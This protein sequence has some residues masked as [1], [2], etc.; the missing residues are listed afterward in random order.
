MIRRGLGRFFDFLRANVVR[1]FVVAAALVVG[2]Y[3]YAVLFGERS[4]LV[5]LE[6]HEQQRDLHAQIEQLQQKNADLQREFFGAGGVQFRATKG[7]K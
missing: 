5:L 4:L 2:Y 3:L 7:I 6:L 1:A